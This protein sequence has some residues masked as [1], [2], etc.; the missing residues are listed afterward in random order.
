MKVYGAENDKRLTGA[1]ETSLFNKFTW[2]DGSRGG[3]I[4][5]PV[6]TK[7]EGKGYLIC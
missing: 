6:V 3:S 1:H 5:V 4:R 2:G 7:E